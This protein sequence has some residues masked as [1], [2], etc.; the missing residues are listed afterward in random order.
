[1]KDVPSQLQGTGM[2]MR[3]K[4]KVEKY[5]SIFEREKNSGRIKQL[6]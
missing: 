2:A 5:T 3:L 4:K 6:F 1:L